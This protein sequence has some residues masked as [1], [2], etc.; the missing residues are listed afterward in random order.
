[1]CK[2]F[3]QSCVPLCLLHKPEFSGN[4]L[5]FLLRASCWV[6]SSTL[7][8]RRVPPK[9]QLIFNGLY[10]FVS[11][12]MELF[13]STFVRISDRTYTKYFIINLNWARICDRG[14]R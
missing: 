6:Y 14:N 11:Q 10:D 12:K 1:M 13:K 5:L 4:V 3:F 7:K 8:C 9:R 2:Y